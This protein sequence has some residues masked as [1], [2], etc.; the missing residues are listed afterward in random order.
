MPCV[1]MLFLPGIHDWY[2]I[3]VKEFRVFMTLYGH[4][5]TF[6]LIVACW[7]KDPVDTADR[8]SFFSFV[9]IHLYLLSLANG[10]E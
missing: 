3:R 1:W 8:L 7:V 5:D 4:I 9:T 6:C 10:Y 2:A